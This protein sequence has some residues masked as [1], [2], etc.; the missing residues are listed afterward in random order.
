MR[1]N[2][3]IIFIITLLVFTCGCSSRE[4]SKGSDLKENPNY[5][6]QFSK[7][8][9]HLNE[10]LPADAYTDDMIRELSESSDFNDKKQYDRLIKNF[11]LYGRYDG[12]AMVV[13]A[14]ARCFSVSDNESLCFINYGVNQAGL[15]NCFEIYD[16]K[17]SRLIKSSQEAYIFDGISD[18]VNVY[19]LCSD[20]KLICIDKE[21]NI[22]EEIKVF[23]PSE[24]DYIAL[25]LSGNSSTLSVV[26]ASQNVI[27]SKKI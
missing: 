23:D 1:K 12:L 8:P 16:L 4:W 25:S 18:G 11:E 10:L 7:V 2:I 5:A 17:T 20:G 6:E 21:K 27:W 15:P 24:D 14:D 22:K 9:Q 13:W 3:F 26:D 19:I